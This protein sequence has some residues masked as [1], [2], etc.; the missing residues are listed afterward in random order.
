MRCATAS[1][2]HVVWWDEHED[3]R[4]E[5]ASHRRVKH[6]SLTPGL[7]RGHANPVGKTVIVEAASAT[8]PSEPFAPRPGAFLAPL[9]GRHHVARRRI[10]A[11]LDDAV[12]VP[13]VVVSAPAGAGKSTALSGWLDRHE[14]ASGWYSLDNDDNDP[15]VF[16]PSVASTLELPDPAGMT[17]GRD[18]VRALFSSGPAA[19][20]TTDGAGARRLPHD[21]QP[22]RAHRHGPVRHRGARD[23][24]CRDQHPP[25]PTAHARQAAGARKPAGDPLPRSAPRQ[26]R[27]RRAAQRPDGHRARP[28]RHWPA[29]RTHRRMGGRGAARRPVI[30]QPAGPQPSSSASSPATTATSRTTCET[31]SWPGFP[32]AC[33]SSWSPPPSSI[34]ST[35]RSARPSPVSKMPRTGSTSSIG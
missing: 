28:V 17:T 8:T 25:R 12:D 27:S 4:G 23:A 6:S 16:W 18:V 31:R 32:I 15:A 33:T 13:L 21:H 1:E 3:Q 30:A 29:D 7:P 24:P 34:G 26:R 2:T 10:D 5:R 35:P 22:G 11:M 19:S 14:G 20:G 9:V